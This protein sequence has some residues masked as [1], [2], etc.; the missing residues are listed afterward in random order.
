MH[1]LVL[2]H[3]PHIA[4]IGL[5]A[6]AT[7]NIAVLHQRGRRALPLACLY[8]LMILLALVNVLTDALF[9][10]YL[11]PVLIN[12]ALMLLF[13]YSLQPHQTPLV[14]RFMRIEYG[15]AL[16]PELVRHGR[17]LTMTWALFFAFV[18]LTS[19]LLAVFAPLATWSWF[20]NVFN[21]V[22]VGLLFLCQ[23]LYRMLRYGKYGR[24][25][26]WTLVTRLAR[27]KLADPAHPLWGG[28][29]P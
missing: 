1:T 25:M 18:V 11:P 9:A 8:G 27:L 13:G 22:L 17:N 21:F 26:P 5:I 10:L 29:R 23:Q 15:A 2:A 4:L 7:A 19:V 3:V 28:T 12:L 24:V 14:E 20:V 16:A 6:I